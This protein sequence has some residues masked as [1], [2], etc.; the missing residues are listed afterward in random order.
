MT[1]RLLPISLASMMLLTFPA[2][3]Q[4]GAQIGINI[5]AGVTTVTLVGAP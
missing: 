1:K 2:F 4:S 3:A 5:A